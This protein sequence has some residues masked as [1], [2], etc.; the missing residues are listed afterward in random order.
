MPIQYRA[1]W[2]VPGGGTGY[3]VFN[4]REGGAVTPD[5]A[6]QNAADDIRVFFTDIDHLLPNEVSI[7]FESEALV[8]DTSTGVLQDVIP[9]TPPASVAGLGSGVW[10]G[11]AGG[12]VDWSTSAIVGGH[13]LRGRTYIVPLSAAAF[14][15][16]GTLAA[17]SIVSLAGA[18]NT[19]ISNGGLDFAIG[20]WSRTHGVFADAISASAPDKSAILRGRRDE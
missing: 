17:A 18:G 19:L 13:R 6:A 20:V 10:V 14:E 4:L 5:Q 15:T 1:V 8:L 3:S 16:D 7:S 11:G 12:R 9:V 2:T